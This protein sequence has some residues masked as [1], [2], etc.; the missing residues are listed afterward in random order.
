MPT[1]EVN[2]SA[3]EYFESGSGAPLVLVHGSLNDHRAWEAQV[4]PLSTR[5]HVIAYSRR[6]HHPN[7]WVGDG[8]DYAVSLHAADLT[9]LVRAL[10][11][12]PAHVVGSS[13]GAYTALVTGLHHP[14]LVRTLVLGEPPAVPLLISDPQNP[15]HL[16]WLLMRNPRTAVVV[17]RFMLSTIRPTQEAL[18][19]GDLE[20]AVR[21]FGDGVLGEGGYD[22]LPSAAKAMI[23]DNAEALKAELLAGNF[24][25]FPTAEARSFT[26]PVLLLYGEHTVD[27]FRLISDVLKT[28]LPN[29]E[30]ATIPRAS[31]DMHSD[32]PEAYTE[33]VLRFLGKHG[34]ASRMA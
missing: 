10:E 33:E 19:R 31:H 15:L 8:S 24:E 3:L 20:E 1:I 14:G 32:N 34:E 25:P 17:L 29:A 18:R 22:R 7:R 30:T 9:A 4:A 5:Y 12:A 2:G 21:R 27:F 28:L 6:Y 16:L 11:I 26:N 13:Y 23:R